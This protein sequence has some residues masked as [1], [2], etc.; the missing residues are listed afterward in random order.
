MNAA[1]VLFPSCAPYRVL[2]L[3][4]F[5]VPPVIIPKQP[6]NHSSEKTI[7]HLPLPIAHR[8]YSARFPENTLAAFAAAYDFGVLAVETD[9]RLSS[10]GVPVCLH[11]ASLERLA[12]SEKSVA[13]TPLSDI[14][15]T[16]S[17]AGRELCLL[18]EALALALERRGSL[19]LDVK[20]QDALPKIHALLASMAVP[21]NTVTLGLRCTSQ[22]KEW[23]KMDS[24]RPILG[25]LA[26]TGEIPD[27]YA[28]G[29]TIVRFWEEDLTADP[30]LVRLAEGRPFWVMAGA[31]EQGGDITLPRIACLRQLG[32]AAVLL[33]DPAL[34]GPCPN[35]GVTA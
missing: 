22:V 12:R 30:R 5:T 33:N 27:F 17:D 7:M 8:G 25:F 2:R 3:I 23:R 18:E 20:A 32:A 26:H 19:L 34:L 11:D 31:R 13:R 10:D 4:S 21:D 1:A 16:L 15:Q 29:G 14:R 6:E 24:K 35:G 28:A 9:V